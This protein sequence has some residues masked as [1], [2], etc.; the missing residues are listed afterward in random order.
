MPNKKCVLIGLIIIMIVTAGC[1]ADDHAAAAPVQYAFE[2]EDINGQVHKL[3]DYQG[4]PVLIRIWNSNCDVSVLKNVGL[5]WLA[6]QE[7]DY[8]LLTVVMPE[9]GGEK[10]RDEFAAWYADMGFISLV[11]L[12]DDEAQLCSDFYVPNLPAQ[13]IFDSEGNHQ[14]SVP[15]LMSEK[16]IM[17]VMSRFTKSN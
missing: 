4:M 9:V 10:T 1:V 2:F 13:L 7:Q 3:S 5:E 11:V 6:E 17:A 16:N 14:L 8:A 12:F 15:G